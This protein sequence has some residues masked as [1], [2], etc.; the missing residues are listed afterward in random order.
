MAEISFSSFGRLIKL[1]ILSRWRDKNRNI[2]SIFLTFILYSGVS[3]N[4][5]ITFRIYSLTIIESSLTP[6]LYSST[7]TSRNLRNH[8]YPYIWRVERL[9]STTVPIAKA[10]YNGKAVIRKLIQYG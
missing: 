2:L 1:I 9:P 6:I 7:Y 5:S 4:Q 3:L 10:P 8:G